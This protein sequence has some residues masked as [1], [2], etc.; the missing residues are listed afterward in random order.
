MR[1]S[2]FIYN[3]DQV[4]INFFSVH[5]C[6]KNSI[7][8]KLGVTVFFFLKKEE[9]INIIFDNIYIYI[10]SITFF[11]KDYNFLKILFSPKAM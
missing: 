6:F 5:L 9:C 11:G 4:I 7:I 10:F 1:D 8:F 3:F 2:C